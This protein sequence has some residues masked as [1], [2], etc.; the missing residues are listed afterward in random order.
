MS[1]YLKEERH[2]S[3]HEIA[4]ILNR[5]DR[6]VWT[7]WHRAKKKLGSKRISEDFEESAG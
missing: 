5:D 7:C 4:L 6:T 1:F 2:L 3:F